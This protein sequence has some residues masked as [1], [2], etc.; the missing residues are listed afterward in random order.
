MNF[1]V[2]QTLYS[3]PACQSRKQCKGDNFFTKVNVSA[4]PDDW[5]VVR[6]SEASHEMLSKASVKI[7]GT[8]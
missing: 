5:L 2:S 1:N 6:R 4:A 8:I 3:D 7:A